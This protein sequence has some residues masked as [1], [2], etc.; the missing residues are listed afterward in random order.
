MKRIRNLKAGLVAAVTILSFSFLVTSNAQINMSAGTTYNQNFNTLASSFGADTNWNDNSTL[1]GWYA[2]QKSGGTITS[3]R[4][5]SG[6]GTSSSL[7][8]YGASGD[9]DRALGSQAGGTPGDFAYG[10]RFVND[11]TNAM[12]NFT[13]LYTGEQWRRVTNAPAQTLAFTYS[14]GNTYTSADAAGTVYT[15]TPFNAL[16]F[17]TPNFSGATTA[18][19]G[20]AGTNRQVF[21]NVMLPGVVV[22]PSEE[23]FFRW[24]DVDDSGSDHAV[25]IDDVTITF[26]A[27]LAKTNPPAIVTQPQSQTNKA[28]DTVS[29]T[30]VASGYEPLSY[31][32]QMDSA[33]LTNSS[34]VTGATSPT[35]SI[36]SVLK[37][38]EGYYS[39]L[40]TNI[41]GSTNTDT[42]MLTV[43]EPGIATQPTSVTNVAGDT[44]H[45]FVTA[46]GTAPFGYQWYYNNAEMDGATSNILDIAN[47]SATNQGN[48]FVVVTNASGSITSS[49]VAL[50]VFPTP[51]TR[52]ARWDF[53]N[54]NDLA[55]PPP[56]E[57]IGVA[58]LAGLASAAFSSGS[59]SDPATMAGSTNA[60]WNTTHYP[61]QGTSNLQHGVEFHVSTTGYQDIVLTWEQRNSDTA[62]KYTRLQYSPDGFTA[63]TNNA[64][65]VV[66]SD[67]NNA[68]VF[69]SSDLSGVSGVNNNPNFAF[70]LVAEFEATAI[71]NANANYVATTPGSS[72]S[73]GQGTI[74]YD[75]MSVYGNVLGTASPIPVHIQLF[76]NKA[77]LTWTNASFA[78]QTAPDV[79]GTYTNIIGATSPWTNPITGSRN[80]FRL[81]GN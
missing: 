11:T 3:Y 63:T 68:F 14:S 13:I 20:N 47:V 6:S 79:T 5:S 59:I 60:G 22:F 74:R 73:G 67:T 40:I 50:R 49:I 62:S 44:G 56:S 35:L 52:L 57:G 28:G 15:W 58:S 42:V 17:W 30:V 45:F 48:Y 69:Y 54:T 61:A 9:S 80:F 77:V 55:S 29:F 76:G 33:I 25:A 24:L 12:T 4:I 53:N 23:I 75:L 37:A 2:S 8:S 39:C 46:A 18:L 70:R 78:L 81:K 51:S 31:Q 65:A 16:D 71:G 1:P 10:V 64:D 43:I 34:R 26:A 66:M 36:S 32:W 7:Y 38:D 27:V 72:Y 41:A 21:S 19:N